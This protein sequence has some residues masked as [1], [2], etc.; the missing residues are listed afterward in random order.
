MKLKYKI[1][2][3]VF[4]VLLFVPVFF[5]TACGNKGDSSQALVTAM[6]N[7]ADKMEETSKIFATAENG[8]TTEDT[9]A[10]TTMSTDLTASFERASLADVIEMQEYANLYV[11]AVE[12][13]VKQTNK[14]NGYNS[15]IEFDQVY[16]GITGSL[17]SGDN[18][19]LYI[20]FTESEDGFLIY[21]DADYID[22]N[23]EGGTAIQY[24][25]HIYAIFDIAY[26]FET[27]TVNRISYNLHDTLGEEFL[28]AVYDYEM[29]KF[30]A[31]FA[32]AI[33]QSIDRQ[34]F[35]N[36]I[37]EKYNA[38]TLELSDLMPAEFGTLEMCSGNIT[39]NANLMNFTGYTID[40]Y[41]EQSKQALAA[42]VV[43]R[44]I[45]NHTSSVKMRSMPMD[46]TGYILLNSVNDAVTYGQNRTSIT[47]YKTDY[48]DYYYFE[49][50]KYKEA[51]KLLD[52]I[53]SEYEAN[54]AD[55]PTTH[56]DVV[57]AVK[58]S[59]TIKGKNAYI[60]INNLGGN[61]DGTK[62]YVDC[63]INSIGLFKYGFYASED[64]KLLLTV[65]V[66]AADNSLSSLRLPS[67]V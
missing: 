27:K 6:I 24:V 18:A 56:I 47:I 14:E 39:D 44:G 3:L 59:I 40:G 53:I 50:I 31:F 29:N 57:K 41:D 8:N 9:P 32:R 51:I 2:S 12:Y 1:L 33:N 55:K 7:V 19:G 37:I 13:L 66:N 65:C 54:Y 10:T 17:F 46:T 22:Y 34:Q 20:G 16:C 61:Y 38:N 5:T 48:K 15:G 21:V 62:F 64:G 36:D 60:G 43:F 30:E 35:C 67:G 45:C 23:Y 63:W 25:R 49:F 58:N 11:Y 26:N 4:A 28:V 42:S 52:G